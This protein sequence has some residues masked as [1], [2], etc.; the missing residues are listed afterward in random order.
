MGDKQFRA[1]E[2][3][4]RKDGDIF[5]GLAMLLAS[6]FQHVLKLPGLLNTLS[7]GAISVVE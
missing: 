2:L 1:A 5:C 3:T 6:N 7:I 4:P